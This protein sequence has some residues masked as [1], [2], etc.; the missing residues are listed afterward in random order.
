MTSLSGSCLQAAQSEDQQCPDFLGFAHLGHFPHPWQ[1]KEQK[2]NINENMRHRS[3]KTNE[4]FGASW[5]VECVEH[6]CKGNTLEKYREDLDTVSDSGLS[7][8]ILTYV[9]HDPARHHYQTG[10]QNLARLFT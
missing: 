10:V 4:G 8:G 6:R 5:V 2:G 9:S 1:R 3:T 7:L